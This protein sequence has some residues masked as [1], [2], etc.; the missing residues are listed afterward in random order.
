MS[1]FYKFLLICMVWQVLG[2]NLSLAQSSSILWAQKS[3]SLSGVGNKEEGQAIAQDASGNTYVAGI[4]E[5]SIIFDNTILTSSRG[6]NAI[7][8][9]KY[10]AAG[11]IVW[12]QKI[13]AGAINWGLD[14]AVDGSGNV[15]V[16]GNFQGMATFGNITLNSSIGQ[17]MFVAKYD[18][19]GNAQWAQR[20][21]TVGGNIGYGHSGRGIAVDRAGNAY[22]TGSF[23]GKI[24]FG[25]V[26]LTSTGDSEIFLAKYNAAGVLQWVQ[27]AGGVDD[28]GGEAVALDEA[29]N[30]YVAGS[31]RN[32]ATFGNSAVTGTTAGTVT[33]FIA[34]YDASGTPLWVRGKAGGWGS[35]LTVDK[36]GN[37]YL[38]TNSYIT[39]YD[40]LGN[41]GWEKYIGYLYL[42]KGIAVDGSNNVYVTGTF[43]GVVTL[44]N[45]WLVSS[46]SND[47]FLAKL[48]AAGNVQWVKK[49]GGVVDDRANGIALDGSGNVYLTGSFQ[50]TATFGNTIL[51]SSGNNDVFVAKYDASGNVHRAHNPVGLVQD[52]VGNSIAVDQSGNIYVTGS[53]KGTASF[54]NTTLIGDEATIFIAKYSSSGTPLW[55]QKVNGTY[56]GGGTSIRFDKL[57]NVY[58]L[59]N[60]YGTAAFGS[61]TLNSTTDKNLG[62]TILFIAKYDTSGKLLWAKKGGEAN[63]TIV[64]EYESSGGTIVGNSMDIDGAGNLYITGNFTG[65]ANFGDVVLVNTNHT[66][67]FNDAFVAKYDASGNP[68]WAKQIGGQTWERGR[69][70]AA[71]NMGG[72]YVTGDFRGTATFGNGSVTTKGVQD[73]F[74]A[75]Y[76]AFGV[77]QW[78]KQLGVSSY[79]GDNGGVAVDNAGNAYVTGSFNG[80]AAFDNMSLSSSSYDMFV[81]KYDGSGNVIW[82]KKA[83]GTG[84]ESGM[85]IALDALGNSYVTGIFTGTTTF[86]NFSFTNNGESDPFGNYDVFIAKFDPAGN[87]VS[88]GRVGG[89]RDDRGNSI[90][91][92]GIGN[93]YITGSFRGTAF[94]GNTALSTYGKEM[95]FVKAR[96]ETNPPIITTQPVSKTITGGHNVSFTVA[97]SGIGLNYQWQV[98]K[99]GG[100]SFANVSNGLGYSG[101]TTATLSI[102]KAPISMTE[103]RYR[104]Q[105]SNGSVSTSSVVTLTVNVPAF[106]NN[107]VWQTV[108]AAGFTTGAASFTSMALDATGKP[109]VAYRDSGNENK[110]SVMRYTGSAWEMVGP[111]GFSQ[112][113]AY[114]TSL[115]IDTDGA[116]YVAYTDGGSDP[117]ATVM[118]FNG[119]RWE[120]VGAQRFTE[121]GAYQTFLSFN[122]SG[123]PYVLYADMSATVMKFNG[124]GWET[125]GSPRF[126]AGNIQAAFLTLAPNGTPYVAYQDMGNGGKATVM[127][128]NGSE[129][130]AVGRAGF[131]QGQAYQTSLA[132]DANGIPYIAF[133][134]A[135]IGG[136][137]TVMRYKGSEWETVG[138]AGISEGLANP[139]YITLDASGTPF[140][141]FEDRAFSGK[142]SVMRF[143][144]TKWEAVGLKG[145]STGAASSITLALD[146]TGTPYV[147]Y[148]DAVNGSKA[149]VM[150]F[151]VQSNA[152]PTNIT[153]SNVTVKENVAA[154]TVVGTFTTTD[155]DA[156]D[157]HAYT[158]VSG[159]GSTDNASFSIDGNKLVIKVS[160]DY[161]KKSSYSIRVRTS[162]GKANGT[163]EK[164]FTIEVVD[165]DEVAPT[166]TAVTIASNNGNAAMAKVGDVVSVSFTASEPVK[167]PTVSIAGRPSTVTAVAS[168]TTQFTAR[169]TM[170][171]GDA[172]GQVS[173]LISFQDEAGNNGTAV[174]ATTNGSKVVFDKT[175]P[176]A[177]ITSAVS[178]LTNSKPMLLTLTFSET[179]SGLKA[180]DL[181]VA[182]GSITKVS[183]ADNRVYAL[184]FTPQSNGAVTVMLPADRVIDAAGN[185]NTASNSWSGSYDGTRPTVTLSSPASASTNAAFTVTFTFSEAVTGFALNDIVVVNGVT[186]E[187]KTTSTSVYTAKVT[188]TAQGTVSVSVAAN[189][190]QDAAGNGNTASSALTRAFDSV[191]PSGYAV[192]FDQNLI[193]FSNQEKV[194]VKVTGAEVGATYSYTITSAGGG[195]P[196]TGTGSVSAA[197]FDINNI[198]VTALADGQLTISL[199]LTDA[200]S[201]TGPEATAKVNKNTRNLIGYTRPAN[202]NVPFLRTYSEIST[203][204]PTTVEAIFSD[205]SKASV[206]V[207]WLADGYNGAVA[208]SYELSGVM[209]LPSGVTNS[210]NIKA[211]I[212]VVVAQSQAPTAITLSRADLDENNVVGAVI[213][214]LTST[215]VDAGDTHTYSLVTGEGSGDNASFTIEGDALKAAQVFDHETKSSYSIRVR[216]TDRGG[217]TFE[218]IKVITVNDVQETVTGIADEKNTLLRLY[219]NPAKGSFMITL[220]TV[221]ESVRLVDSRGSTVLTVKINAA[222]A[223]VN[224]EGV[225]TGV[226]TAIITSKDK[227]YSRRVV[228]SK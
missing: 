33:T 8:I 187:F 174:S 52:A 153:L 161:E 222:Q 116:P 148:S 9:A 127:R 184:E 143:D 157:T 112:R 131:T 115:A 83:G 185:G 128:F 105:V 138:A 7:F 107:R 122:S 54:G 125:V 5:N 47:V 158:L 132:L 118:K 178:G 212:T 31:F 200:A 119:S 61:T 88:A 72:V 10:N 223:L 108:G 163:F 78:V 147:A 20:A 26:T 41:Q 197:T 71:D 93:T 73:V 2:S 37:A 45:T 94:F 28:D 202:V 97:A 55:A 117:K 177:A 183:T 123:V 14:I 65:T 165:L 25:S 34:K 49:S 36:G 167:L 220:D 199:R 21:G 162:D 104:V 92:D 57:S 102:T 87:V 6:Q 150:Q 44:G 100:N 181:T 126:S 221:I 152:T 43:S 101:A 192:A 226:Y 141:A 16:T 59:G 82:A 79:A 58:L 40:A 96:L 77:L 173:F 76:D 136:K 48:D 225:A 210:N 188:P 135:S 85:S 201:N 30:I 195:T 120:P 60:F 204:L 64:N 145:F 106:D 208:G 67:S 62:G 103:Y 38:M 22:V 50:G 172:E 180:T 217:K 209:T 42:G 98:S 23:G 139:K 170:A 114:Y 224:I 154:N 182:N 214:T 24:T 151:A 186:S 39:K 156:G 110:A 228:V 53:F 198:N 193:T 90:T 13:E 63:T 140:V 203:S 80:T 111:A 86:G 121:I 205:N 124:S 75:R 84:Y 29:G 175:R 216:S 81:V 171:T 219:P 109:I 17:N 144:G 142:I 18:A 70:L 56:T 11:A 207:S 27:Q 19:S 149:T 179:V 211:A 35:A 12:A 95:F 194:S 160:P 176:S 189:A 159:T 191:A 169:Y 168:S 1:Q 213:G 32:S 74:V 215:D 129:W 51:T 133:T 130:E 146:V 190:A 66:P 164:A 3:T 227:V 99:D 89:P 166:L 15:Y 155:S 196:V 137:V 68:L 46:G 69:A 134:D 91:V 206:S 218:A 113:D 4:F